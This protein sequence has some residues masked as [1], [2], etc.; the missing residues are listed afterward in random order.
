[1]TTRLAAAA[2][3]ALILAGLAMPALAGCVIAPDHKSINVVADNPSNDEKNCA[4][5]CK[6]DTR[7][8]VVEI[9]CGG[10][11]PPLVKGQSLC[12][13]DKPDAWYKKVISASDKCE[14]SADAAPADDAPKAAPAKGFTCKIAPDGKSVDAMIANPYKSET[15]CQI[16]CQIS[17]TNAGTTFGLSCTD[18]VAPGGETAVLC[19]KTYDKGR[20]VKVLEGQ[21][22]CLDPTPAANPFGKD[23]DTDAPPT[24]PAKLRE[25]IRKKLQQPD[26]PNSDD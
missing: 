14:A 17:T 18:T 8:G 5:S 19:S 7:I 20:L 13:F 12:A 3:A 9:G 2:V 6:V 22:S 16:D 1:M 21:G 23:T 10:V 26:A 11:T 15:S 25:Y 4:V 24:D